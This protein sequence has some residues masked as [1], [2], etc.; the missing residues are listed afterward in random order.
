[1]RRFL[2][3]ALG[4]L[5]LATEFSPSTEGQQVAR[6]RQHRRRTVVIGNPPT[7]PPTG[8]LAGGVWTEIPNSAM[9]ILYNTA[10]PDPPFTAPPGG[11]P[12]DID[13]QWNANQGGNPSAGAAP[14]SFINIQDGESG[15]VCIGNELIVWGGGHN[16]GAHNGVF[17]VNALTGA[18]RRVTIP[19]QPVSTT[20]G[21]QTNPDG[22]PVSRHTYDHLATDGTYLYTTGGG[23]WPGGGG[24]NSPNAWRLHIANAPSL[25]SS[26]PPW[27]WQNLA[28]SPKA[29]PTGT[30]EYA[31]G[32]LYEL[33]NNG[34]ALYDIATNI[35]T[36]GFTGSALAL[37]DTTLVYSPYTDFFYGVGN[38]LG[39]RK[40]ASAWLNNSRTNLPS[41][42]ITAIHNPGNTYYPPEH[43]V[44]YWSGGPNL[45][46][47]NEDSQAWEV[48]TLAGDPGPSVL[49][50]FPA[51]ETFGRLSYCGGRIILVNGVQNNMW[52]VN[53]PEPA[54]VCGN[55][56][57][58]EGEDCDAPSLPT[59]TCSATCQSITPGPVCGNLIVETPEECDN[60]PA[61]PES[62]DGCSAT[63]VSET[64]P[65][66]SPIR[67]TNYS[68]PPGGSLDAFDAWVDGICG[69]PRDQWTVY[70]VGP[71]QQYPSTSNVNIPTSGRAVVRIHWQATE[72]P[73][74]VIQDKRCVEV[75]GIA[76]GPGG[77]GVR[78]TDPT[79]LSWSNL[80]MLQGINAGKAYKLGDP[81][82][83]GGL[84]VRG[85]SVQNTTTSSC[86]VSPNNKRFLAI[87]DSNMHQCQ[88]HGILTSPSNAE[89]YVRVLRTSWKQGAS[90]HL[91]YIDRSARADIIDN[92][93]S[94][95]GGGHCIRSVAHVTHSSG[96][97]ASNVK[98][99]GTVAA[100]WNKP[101]A[102]CEQGG[103]VL[104]LDCQIGMNPMEVY[105]CSDSLVEDNTV[106]KWELNQ[107]PGC[108]NL[109]SR[110]DIFSCE[111]EGKTPDGTAWIPLRPR[112][113]AAGQPFEE[114][115]YQSSGF[116]DIV[117]ADIAANGNNS[118]FAF[119]SRF[120]DN[121]CF[122]LGPNRAAGHIIAIDSSTPGHE[123]NSDI[124]GRVKDYV[125][126]NPGLTCAQRAADTLA[127]EPDMSWLFSHVVPDQEG[128][129]C[130]SGTT[131][132]F[133]SI[134][135]PDNW[136]E[137]QYLTYDTGNVLKFCPG[138]YPDS[139]TTTGTTKDI[140]SNTR[141]RVYYHPPFPQLPS[142]G[143]TSTPSTWP[144]FQAQCPGKAVNIIDLSGVLRIEISSADAEP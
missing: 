71:G 74:L 25:Q 97:I 60:D 6:A 61:P 93:C 98:L 113:F 11:W 46:T 114:A 120:Q 70:E 87:E 130:N 8:A 14:N 110:R 82:V 37:A 68:T 32:K 105:D 64:V 121:Q 23:L 132:D 111:T 29:G 85:V 36:N 12:A 1:M 21:S 124:K 116:W 30:L 77:P 76:D 143:C 31:N 128:S 81:V 34:S 83:D 13:D 136:T 127:T 72:Y 18:W 141:E 103:Q 142:L 95:P 15:G 45:T 47:W 65:A 20:F 100:K 75:I 125:Q 41:N 62:G 108:W 91:L 59:A 78:S 33:S 101:G 144:T 138:A 102:V 19:S 63:C 90:N 99:D 137:R 16:D 5:M 80:P 139:C 10:P 4:L 58:E 118:R 89:F 112:E 66:E 109:R 67:W 26:S 57:V 35:W 115:R 131:P 107:A 51:A 22:T 117:R 106:I 9:N 126:N 7:P 56:V 27:G 38:D 73:R 50:T 140:N 92:S 96:N 122:A 129:L 2:L 69:L 17:A 55:D 49:G 40:P 94:E 48:L 52:Y 28:D 135:H 104:D 39:W 133:N 44:V 134:P 119:N 123:P 79:D 84:I 88:Q 54:P 86:V 24:A 53:V 42:P 3:L 43:R